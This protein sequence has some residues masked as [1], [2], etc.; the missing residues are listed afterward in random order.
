MNQ[1]CII[2]THFALGGMYVHIVVF[3]GH[4]NKQKDDGE[5]VRLQ[6]ASIC[7]FDCVRDKFVADESSV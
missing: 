1:I 6:E 3:I 5:P 2:K 4:S 7:L